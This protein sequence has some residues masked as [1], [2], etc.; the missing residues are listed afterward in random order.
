MDLEIEGRVAVV[1]GAA[2]GI[3]RATARRLAREG[4]RVVAVDREKVVVE[5]GDPETP[6]LALAADVADPGSVNRVFD[7]TIEAFGR[8]DILVCSAGVFET[9]PPAELSAEEWDRV[10]AV[11]L[12]GSF[13]CAQAAAPLMGRNGWGRIVLLSSM[14]AQ[15]GGLAAGS[16]YVASKAGVMGL[17]RSLAVHVG[18]MGVTVNCVNPGTIETPMTAGVEREALAARTPLRRNGTP[19][20]VADM[21]VVLSSERSSFVTGAHLSINGGLVAD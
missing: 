15:T 21:I 8:V 9:R 5:A 11:N 6:A 1:T 19:D 14:A 20:E 10:V 16:A 17:T 7:T 3:G 18:P 4:C 2:S 13:L 12:R